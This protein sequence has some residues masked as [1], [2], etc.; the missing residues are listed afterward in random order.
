MQ[1]DVASNVNTFC[2][3][4]RQQVVYSHHMQTKNRNEPFR[5]GE[6]ES[7]SH[8]VGKRINK[9]FQYIRLNVYINPKENPVLE[10]PVL[11]CEGGEVAKHNRDLL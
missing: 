9:S 2:F 8:P 5:Q 6:R 11:K 10:N 1:L 7:L 3:T 4:H